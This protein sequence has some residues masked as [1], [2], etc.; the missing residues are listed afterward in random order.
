VA[1]YLV[2]KVQYEKA[3]PK[4]EIPDFIERIVPELVLEMY[5]AF[6]FPLISPGE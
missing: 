3:G 5:V 4:E 6:S 1:E 2:Y